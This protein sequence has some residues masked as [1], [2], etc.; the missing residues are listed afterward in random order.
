[1][2]QTINHAFF[3]SQHAM[4]NWLSRNICVGFVCFVVVFVLTDYE[5]FYCQTLHKIAQ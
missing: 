3:S 4:I 5:H 2:I 1:M